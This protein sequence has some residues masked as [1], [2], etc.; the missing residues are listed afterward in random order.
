MIQG[1]RLDKAI[2]YISCITVADR[3]AFTTHYKGF[4]AT[5]ADTHNSDEIVIFRPSSMPITEKMA[6]EHELDKK[7]IELLCECHV[8]VEW[9]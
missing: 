2:R 5:V 4:V 7:E 8:S 1:K 3:L 9:I 6:D